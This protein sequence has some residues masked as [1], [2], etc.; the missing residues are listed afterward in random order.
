MQHKHVDKSRSFPGKP[1]SNQKATIGLKKLCFLLHPTLSHLRVWCSHHRLTHTVASHTEATRSPCGFTYRQKGMF[2]HTHAR[3]FKKWAAHACTRLH[4]FTYTQKLTH[5][6]TNKHTHPAHTPCT[7]KTC[8]EVSSCLIVPLHT[9]T[10]N[11]L[12]S[13]HVATHLRRAAC[14]S[15]SARFSWPASG[16]D[17]PRTCIN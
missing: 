2:T 11:L 10:H 4:T 7:H 14:S 13:A 3:L 5:M 16:G 6:H 15:A 12:R 9:H 1:P 8:V 17:R